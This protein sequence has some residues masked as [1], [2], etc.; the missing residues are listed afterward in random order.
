M[1]GPEGNPK[2]TGAYIYIHSV[3]FPGQRVCLRDS[4][5]GSHYTLHSLTFPRPP[6][7]KLSPLCLYRVSYSYHTMIYCCTWY[8]V[9]SSSSTATPPATPV[10]LDRTP[11][12][13]GSQPGEK[14]RAPPSGPVRWRWRWHWS[15]EVAQHE[16][17]DSRR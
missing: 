2:L 4:L 15:L 14:Q 13:D 16:L 1:S 12:A 5:F 6:N 11:T 17:G 3:P 10:V 9:Y 8:L 7:L